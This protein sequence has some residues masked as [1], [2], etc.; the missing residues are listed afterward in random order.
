MLVDQNVVSGLLGRCGAD[1]VADLSRGRR[2]TTVP[3]DIESH[4]VGVAD[5]SK[6]GLD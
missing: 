5:H 1:P 3:E 6:C 4:A 2:C